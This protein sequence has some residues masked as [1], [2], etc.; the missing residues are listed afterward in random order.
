MCIRDS[1]YIVLNGEQTET[2][3]AGTI[4]NYTDPKATAFAAD[5]TSLE[6][7]IAGTGTV[8][9]AKPGTY[10]IEY[11]YQAADGTFAYPVTRTVHVVDSIPPE[12]TL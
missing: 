6:T 2:L 11:I 4:P 9:P 1:P 5:G 10:T 12:L 3:E 8:D 7:D